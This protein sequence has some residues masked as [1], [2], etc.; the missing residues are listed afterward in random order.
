MNIQENVWSAL[1]QAV[2]RSNPPKTLKDLE[3][4]ILEEGQR[5]DLSHLYATL[6]PRTAE[7]AA[8]GGKLLDGAWRKPANRLK[9]KHLNSLA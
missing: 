6:R 1:E 5:L 8:R 9:K 2:W 3:R 4:R 7:V